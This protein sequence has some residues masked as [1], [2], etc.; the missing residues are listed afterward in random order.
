MVN[1]FI[2]KLQNFRSFPAYFPKIIN[3]E[4]MPQSNDGVHPWKQIFDKRV[5][6]HQQSLVKCPAK[7]CN[8]TDRKEYEPLLFLGSSVRKNFDPTFVATLQGSSLNTWFPKG[9]IQE[10]SWK[11]GW[12]FTSLSQWNSVYLNCLGKRKTARDTGEFEWAV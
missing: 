3:S 1:E 12:I 9:Q 8:F 7:S 6:K 11:S 2:V 4:E 10:S 5:W